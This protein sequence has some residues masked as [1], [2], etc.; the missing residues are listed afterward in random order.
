M[1]IIDVLTFVLILGLLVFI[2]ELGHFIFAKRAK[3]HVYTFSIGMG[4][5]LYKFNRKNDETEYC[6]KLL[7]IG[8]FVSL[9]GEETDD[10][11]EVPDSKK[12]NNKTFFERFKIMAA[13]A[14]FNF[15]LAFVLLFLIGVI[16]GAKE[17]AP[18]VGNLETEYNAINSEMETGDKIIAV[19]DQKIKT[20]E[21]LLIVLSDEKYI[22]EGITFK[23]IDSKGNE[24]ET[25]IIPTLYE[26]D[27]QSRYVFGFEIV[28]KKSRSFVSIIKFPFIELGNNIMSMIKILS[29]IF[30]GKL[31]V[32]NLAGPVGIYSIVSASVDSGFYSVL[33]LI[34]LLSINLGFINLLPFPAFDG[35]RIVFLI[36]EKI[37]KKAI[38][39]KVENAINMVG[40]S[41]LMLLLLFIS[42][43]DIG[44]LI[45]R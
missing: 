37:R 27:N 15:I 35:G 22:K 44:R 13:G 41:L 31:G 21:D 19:G 30:G 28:N 2:H 38:P 36:I 12:L 25:F 3:V 23:L 40:F 20:T 42:I 4:P 11:K 7:P 33:S 10:D 39:M 16:Y 18:Y 17:P 24:K 8:G 9:A 45:G 1:W 14:T 34:A 26:E 29:K 6:I 43:N 5:T 32:D